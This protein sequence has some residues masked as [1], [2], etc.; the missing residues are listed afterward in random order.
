ML[1]TVRTFRENI[2][3]SLTLTKPSDAVEDVARL[4]LA[5]VGTHQVDTAMTCTDLFWALA[6]VNVCEQQGTVSNSYP[7]H[8]V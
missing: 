3:P 7:R 1:V 8:K 6:L 4:A 5:A 2:N